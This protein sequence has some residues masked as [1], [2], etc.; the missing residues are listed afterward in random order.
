LAGVCRFSERIKKLKRTVKPM[1]TQRG[2]RA[3]R[4]SQPGF[5]LIELLVVI[6]IIAILAALLLPA[7]TKAKQKAQSIS[8]MNNT[9]QITLAW[10]MYAN[11]GND[12]LA[13]NDFDWKTTYYNLSPTASG[14]TL[15]RPTSKN[16]VV[17]SMIENLDT[18][19]FPNFKN[20]GWSELTCADTVISPY[21]PNRNCYHCP[22][23]NYQDQYVDGDLHCRSY[24]MNSAVG[25]TMTSFYKNGSPAVGAPV[26]GGWLPGAAYNGNQTTWLTYPKMSSF[27]R[28]GPANTWIIMDENPITINDGSFAVSA[29][30]NPG[31]TYLIDYPTGLHGGAGG[32]SFAD[33]HSTVHK[34]KD[35]RTYTPDANTEHGNGGGGTTVESHEARGDLC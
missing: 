7:L 25:T 15:T 22:A 11:D 2:T 6:A 1:K 18:I 19:D 16:W 13:P 21:Q 8:C 23:D 32:L 27:T 9:K 34:W 14:N 29:V 20:M 26:G 3:N 5:T 33:G 12:V 4:A 17:G 31:Q 28:P 35:T 24:S 30:A 10:I